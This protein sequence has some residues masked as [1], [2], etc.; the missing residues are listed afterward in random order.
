[1]KSIV[2]VFST[3]DVVWNVN[4]WSMTISHL[5]SGDI[6]SSCSMILC[7]IY[8]R[9]HVVNPVNCIVDWNF[10]DKQGFDFVWR[11]L[12][13]CTVLYMLYSWMVPFTVNTWML[14]QTVITAG[15]GW[16]ADQSRTEKPGD[17][18]QWTTRTLRGHICHSC[19]TGVVWYYAQK[20]VIAGCRIRLSNDLQRP[21]F[22][23]LLFELCK[24]K[25]L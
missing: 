22:F 2:L 19:K 18:F 15:M 24:L 20:F 16:P 3:C 10:L 17:Y 11:R 9:H 21:N 8:S 14:C 12:I 7:S 1:V 23:V 4:T 13:T 25:S 5:H 6:S